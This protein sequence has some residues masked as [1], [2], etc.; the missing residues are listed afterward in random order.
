MERGGTG[1]PA[2]GPAFARLFVIQFF[3]WSAMFALWIY[4]VPIMAVDVLHVS[5][6]GKDGLQ[7]AIVTVSLCFSAYALLGAAGSLLLPRIVARFGHAL[8]HGIALL[9]GAAGLALFSRANGVTM[10]VPAFLGIGIGWAAMGSVPYAVLSA[11]TPP[12]RGA[13]F[14]RLFAF[15]TVIPQVVTTVGLVLLADR[16]FGEDRR[17]VIALAAAAMAV[18]GLLTLVWRRT[19]A[20]ADIAEAEW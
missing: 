18:S 10:L 6:S 15:S 4:A 2:F 9:C 11:L 5:D 14:T 19:F 1:V 7:R 20:A 13:H 12:G 16:L 3:S 17:G 8:V